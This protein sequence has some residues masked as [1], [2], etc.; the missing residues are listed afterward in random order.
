MKPIYIGTLV[1]LCVLAAVLAVIMIVLSNPMRPSAAAQLIGNEVQ[2]E[3]SWSSNNMIKTTGAKTRIAFIA[4]PSGPKVTKVD[5]CKVTGDERIGGWIE[6]DRSMESA[7]LHVYI[8]HGTF[9]VPHPC[10]GRVRIR[11][12]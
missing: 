7:L 11:R 9:Q 5:S 3:M 10:N 1:A 8:D 2:I 4:D 6:T 12:H